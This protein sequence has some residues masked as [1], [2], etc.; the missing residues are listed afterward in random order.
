VT[1]AIATGVAVLA[2]ALGACASEDARPGPAGS[3]TSRHSNAA[4]TTKSKPACVPRGPENPRICGL[5]PP[6][7]RAQEETA[8]KV[9][10]V[11][12]ESFWVVLPDEVATG[13]VAVPQVPATV[14]AA[15]TTASPR[16]AA[17][18]Y[19]DGFP[20]CE[21]VVVSRKR[22]PEPL[23][24]WDDASRWIADLAV[25]TVDSGAWTLVLSQ[26][27]ADHA[28][29]VGRAIRASVDADGY[30]RLAGAPL[31]PDWAAVVLWVQAGR[32]RH[33]VIHVM[34]GCEQTTKEPDLGGS[35]AGPE[36][37]PHAPDSASGGT[38]CAGG[39]YWVDVAFAEG[40]R[41][42]LLHEQLRIVPAD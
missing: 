12:G 37:E 28:E 21:P 35:D 17:D 13:V 39:R 25:T 32:S 19:C 34:P 20:G 42:Q 18:R 4:S 33:H 22:V 15:V 5:A 26:V 31:H 6:A 24:R 40:P 9:T 23:V 8:Y 38:W 16:A 1:R 30:P 7:R 27:D 3:E 29:R 14:P 11:S 10:T 41:L 36:L 2:L